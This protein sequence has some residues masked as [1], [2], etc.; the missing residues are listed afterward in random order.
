MIET[1]PESHAVTGLPTVESG[2]C[3]IKDNITFV[4]FFGATGE[5]DY[6]IKFWFQTVQS[7][8][9]GV[10]AIPTSAHPAVGEDQ[11]D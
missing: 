11:G 4:A 9:T 6:T 8:K 7:A 2:D 10:A 1:D 5:V 3:I